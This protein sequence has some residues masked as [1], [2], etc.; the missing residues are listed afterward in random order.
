MADNFNINVSTTVN[1]NELK[2]LLVELQ[3]INAEIAKMNTLS[4]DNITKST[5]NIVDA[6][7]KSTN[8]IGKMNVVLSESKKVLSESKESFDNLPSS[9]KEAT[10][11][12]IN[13]N[14]FTRKTSEESKNT[15]NVLSG[16]YMELGA[17]ITDLSL[18]LPSFA[19][20]TIKAFGAE[21][22]AIQKLSAAVRANGGNVSEVLPIMQQFASDMQTIT[23]YADDQILSM[24][25]VATSMGVLPNQMQE[26]IKG[27]I[28]LSSALGMD[29]Q[30]ATRASSAAIQGKTELL[31]RYI[32]TLSTCK[33]EEEK[34]AKVQ[35]FSRNGF[36]QA[37]ASMESVEGRLKAAANA[38]GNLQEVIGEAFVPTVKIVA[39]LVQGLCE[40]FTKYDGITKIL[41]ISLSSLAVGFA[42]TKVGGLLN[43]AKMF[44]GLTTATKGAT[45]AMH[46]LNLAIKANPLGL[47]A[48]L[49]TGAIMGIIS[50]TDYLSNLE[51]EEE[52]EAEKQREAQKARKKAAEETQK[53]T[54][55]IEEFEQ[56]LKREGE[57]SSQVAERI[58]EL[59]EEIEKLENSRGQWA[60]GE[61][62]K[63]A[64]TLIAKKKE[65]NELQQTFLK[66]VNDT[67]KA[68]YE[69]ASNRESERKYR[70]E[71][72]L[73]AARKTGIAHIIKFKEAELEHV[74]EL[75]ETVKLQQQY[76]N[77]HAHLVKTEEDR[78]RIMAEAEKYASGSI[79]KQREKAQI[80]KWLNSE[81]EASKEKQRSLDLEILRARASGNEAQAKELEGKLRIAQLTNEIF[82]A[83][84]KEGMSKQ[85]LVNLQESASK[86]AEERY[87]LEKSITEEAERQ[88]LAKNAQAKIEDIII[89]NKIEQLKA[90]G[91][92]AEAKELEQEREIKRTLAGLGDVVSDDDKK[93]LGNM[94]RSTNDFK[95]LSGDKDTGSLSGSGRT[96]SSARQRGNPATVS[97]KYAELYSEYQEAKKAGTAKDGWNAFRDQQRK[98]TPKPN[99][100]KI[101][102]QAGRFLEGVESTSQEM[103]GQKQAQAPKKAEPPAKPKQAASTALNNK[104][105]SMGANG[106]TA[107]NDSSIATSLK[108][109]QSTLKSIDNNVKALG[110]KK[111]G[112]E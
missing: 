11:H 70:V 20:A 69:F 65:L 46:G 74:K 71:M 98:G 95:S 84:R 12:I 36:S 54:S 37:E 101:R 112:N 35:E 75:E 86:Q 2:S 19:T 88:N 103:T 7:G 1:L 22:V 109:M 107:G 15:R 68:E 73:N 79:E 59:S 47:I 87:N 76:Y 5:S 41:T 110:S 93:K 31:T 40:I 60:E 90:E 34:L 94:M 99:L 63:N 72:E 89:A 50:L 105:D 106:K 3:A 53:A 57:T 4:F 26:V 9:I 48:S 10:N 81:S 55:I 45:T 62:V 38:W 16:A 100:S 33:S 27:A 64:E 97:G 67:A 96:L 25:G 17:K 82:E 42:F 44:V 56:S 6:V 83:S 104:L 29:L 21:E 43:V 14:E 18:K 24:Q 91:K 77:D 52:K 78:I 108:D 30:T 92:L 8:E 61:Q 39:S 80:E 51:T 13:Y 102:V 28:G 23:G 85:E 58:N 49:V 111:K 66:K 32:P